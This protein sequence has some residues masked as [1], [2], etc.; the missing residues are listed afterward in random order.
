MLSFFEITNLIPVMTPKFSCADFTFPLLPHDKVLRLLNLLEFE[1]VDLGIF[2]ERSHHF[3]SKIHEDPRKAAEVLGE[4]LEK[5]GLVAS[6]V[7]MQTGPEPPEAAVNDPDEAVRERNRELM[8]S[9][10][11]FASALGCKHITGLPGVLQPD[12]D[13]EA[14]W[15][16]AVEETRRRMEQASD[17]GITYSVEPHVGSIIPDPERTLKFLEAVPGLTLTLDYGHFIY[18]G[19]SNESAHP[20]LHYASHFHAR[21]GAKDMLQSTVKDNTI[22]YKAI[23]QRLTEEDYNGYF[24]LEYV[25]IDWEGCNR[26][27][28][29]SETLLLRERLEA[30][31]G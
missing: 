13:D 3:P 10:I 29:L 8:G 6:D 19:M 21:G 30:Y 28:N 24:C 12:T 27:D 22:D 4:A 5:N 11:Q 7:F 2:E 15:D 14:D 26:T 23:M 31:A 25:W 20:L 16:L 9:M 18:Q 1:A 17:A